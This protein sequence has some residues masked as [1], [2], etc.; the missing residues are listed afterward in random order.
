M[1]GKT[2]QNGTPTPTNPVDI[3]VTPQGIITVGGIKVTDS[4]SLPI[5]E[6]SMSG[7]T[8]QNG[9]PTPTNP[10]DIEVTP[11]GIITVDFTDGTNYQT[12]EL[13]CPR[14]FTKWDKLQKIDGVWNWVFKSRRYI[15][16]GNE[17]FIA[18]GA[19]YT[20]G[21]STNLFTNALS[22]VEREPNGYM[23][24]L[25]SVKG[26]WH[27]V[28]EVG[29]SLN[30]V[31]LH[32]RLPNTLLGVSD[33]ATKE[34]KK[35]AY[36]SYLKEEYEK[37][38]PYSLLYELK[39]PELIPL[40]LSEQNK[41]NAI[42]MYA[43]NTEITNTGGCN[44]ELTYTVDTKAYVEPEL[45]PLSLSEQNKLNAITMYA[46]NTEITNTGGCNMELTYTVD[47]KAYVDAKIASVVKS[48][49]E[50]QKALL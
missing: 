23:E 12:I 45:I 28:N 20:T 41:L 46:P 50:T 7:K 18:A 8:V 40:S 31:Q 5:E 3:E 44:M 22:N 17:E 4:S 24:R 6:F 35:T 48:V 21:S 34:E 15:I 33:T 11:Q 32:M 2:V 37:G 47:T 42:T 29:F 19:E 38:K 25:R 10:V 14:E 49:V 36:V 27:K 39:E 16:T 43:P 13:N 30:S 9:T 26:V 1:S